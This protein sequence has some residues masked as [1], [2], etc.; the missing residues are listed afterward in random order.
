MLDDSGGQ[1]D[2]PLVF[3]EEE[4]LLIIALIAGA[5]KERYYEERTE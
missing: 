2:W 3:Q 1:Q 4:V 5:G